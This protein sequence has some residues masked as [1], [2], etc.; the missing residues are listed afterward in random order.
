[1]IIKLVELLCIYTSGTCISR[2][3]SLEMIA[4]LKSWL[5]LGSIL[6]FQYNI[7]CIFLNI[8]LL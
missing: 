2:F 7:F 5:V 4:I 6:K 1:M 3:S 8:S